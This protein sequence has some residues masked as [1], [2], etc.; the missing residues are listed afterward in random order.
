MECGCQGEI[1]MLVLTRKVGQRI[2]ISD[3]IVV[4][5]LEIQGG[6]V[7][8]GIKAPLG[9]PILREELLLTEHNQ[10]AQPAPSEVP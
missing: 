1:N 3:S 9:V 2:V 6:R 4:E 7:R 8:I 5:I 10:A